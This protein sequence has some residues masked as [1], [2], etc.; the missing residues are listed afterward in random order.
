MEMAL[1]RSMR[2]VPGDEEEAEEEGYNCGMVVE[3]R[4]R[5]GLVKIAFKKQ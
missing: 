2:D 1:R 4:R 3:R 5:R